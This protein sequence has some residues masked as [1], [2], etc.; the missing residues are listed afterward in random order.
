MNVVSKQAEVLYRVAIVV[1]ADFRRSYVGWSRYARLP[2]LQGSE[3][4]VVRA[5]I[6]FTACAMWFI[7]SIANAC[8]RN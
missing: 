7:S 6:I 3:R 4:V 1:D 8:L 5:V 2:Y